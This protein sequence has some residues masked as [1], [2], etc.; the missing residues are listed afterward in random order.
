MPKKR[1][2]KRFFTFEM[3]SRNA[4]DTSYAEK[5]RRRHAMHP[6]AILSQLKGMPAK[7]EKPMSKL[8][9]VPLSL[10]S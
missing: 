10:A 3:W 8:K 7:N 1:F 4:G 6:S 2:S 5:I 9:K